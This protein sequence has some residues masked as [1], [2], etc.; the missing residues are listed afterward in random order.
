MIQLYKVYVVS[1]LRAVQSLYHKCQSTNRSSHA[2]LLYKLIR[3]AFFMSSLFLGVSGGWYTHGLTSSQLHTRTT[4]ATV[5][6]K[7]AA[8]ASYV[9]AVLVVDNVSQIA[10]HDP[11]GERFPAAQLFVDL[12]PAGDEVGSVKISG[13]H[14]SPQQNPG[15]HALTSMN[16]QGK[17]AL[18]QTLTQK[19]FGPVEGQG[20]DAYPAYITPALQEAGAMLA[21]SQNRRYV[22]IMTDAVALSDD[23]TFCP[24]APPNHKWFCAVQSL[25]Q[26]NISVILLGFTKPGSE[27]ALLPT[28]NYIESHGG[29]VLT[30]ADGAGL[31]QRLASTY[32][33]LLTRIHSTMFA[34]TVATVPGALTLDPR[35]Q[36][37]S[38]TFVALGDPGV[39]LS[40]L[41]TPDGVQVAGKQTNDGSFY[42]S[43]PIEAGYWLETVS[44]GTL[45]GGWKLNSGSGPPV[46]EL[47]VI[48]VSD[49]HFALLNPGLANESSD[50]STR[51]IQQQ[52]P[53]VL[54]AS[55]T[56]SG[57][58]PLTTVP[59]VANPSTNNVAFSG[60]ALPG[61][62]GGNID[63]VLPGANALDG[64][65]QVGL[66][67][68]I[69]PGAYLTKKFPITA[70]A[71]P[72]GPQL[73]VPTSSSQ[74]PGTSIHLSAQGTSS[75]DALAIYVQPP[76]SGGGWQQVATG[77]NAASGDYVP[78][79]GCGVSYKVMATDE[80]RGQDANG[81]YDYVTYVQ[82]LYRSNLQQSI[83]GQAMAQT[84]PY[85][86]WGLWGS[87]QVH[88]NVAFTSTACTAQSM[89]LGLSM[90]GI[91]T[92][93]TA[94]ILS[95]A[96]SYS[97][98]NGVA[99]FSVLN[100]KQ[101]T[102][103]MSAVV[104]G[105]SWSFTT[106][107]VDTLQVQPVIQPRQAGPVVQKGT[108][109]VKAICPSVIT[110][111]WRYPLISGLSLLLFTILLSQMWQGILGAVVRS[112]LS[113]KVKFEI[114]SSALKND[115]GDTTSSMKGETS[116]PPS[117]RLSLWYLDRYSGA[118]G[119]YY[120]LSWEYSVRS[121]L[122]FSL[123][124]EEGES[125][126][127]IEAT[128]NAVGMFTPLRRFMQK[129]IGKQMEF[130][131]GEPIIIGNDII[132]SELKV[133][134]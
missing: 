118:D 26:Q 113:G 110:N 36:L 37:L 39:S 80:V 90:H 78:T 67:A 105:C 31:F 63:A 62:S 49:A 117:Q 52:G 32:T 5:A 126:M 45:G 83:S 41:Q 85:L 94:V 132:W 133:L 65:L 98:T 8:S 51:I 111:A 102:I 44:E 30:V 55:V 93:G 59:F 28:K 92:S 95:N 129:P 3:S 112:Y 34:T 50:V 25:E 46:R 54:R 15:Y 56:D 73:T 42:H 121:L 115:E 124:S 6:H 100:N 4:V 88:W 125:R 120:K 33:D 123:Q 17:D 72:G 91:S 18:R 22:I 76:N 47:L 1:P 11:G 43:A 87:T 107:H 119:T 71:G 9:S 114:N 35:A 97:L 7:A 21:P 99:A 10:T 16:V 68:A 20:N 134:P 84:P 116:I 74:V 75:A 103:Q 14:V 108:W 127:Y 77:Q 122:T 128:S 27:V 130:Y 2:G 101:T 29:T 106:D 19:T 53:V 38:A 69:A 79:Q 81:Q 96:P 86:G 48:V 13:L 12:V 131:D 57:G 82:S 66:G 58:Q 89:A 64:V 61:E 60:N 24:G 23:N 40:S 109:Q 70:D 104:S